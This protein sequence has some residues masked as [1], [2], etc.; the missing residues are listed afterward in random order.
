MENQAVYI[1][2]GPCG[3]GKS[4]V[5]KGL[6]RRMERVVL[7]EGD[8]LHSMF[9]GEEQPSWN[10][11]LSIVW[12]NILLLTK[13]F[14]ANKLTI[15]IDYVVE[16]ELKWFCEQLLVEQVKI[17]YVVLRADEEALVKRLTYRGDKYLIKRSLLLLNQLEND[18]ANKRHLYDATSKK[19]N[20]IIEDIQLRITDF[21]IK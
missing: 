4:T 18:E 12:E 11:Q 20:K 3:V 14:L 21:E 2:S 5:T 13:N 7:I 6:V 8:Q 16:D 19:P 10:E 1:F 9:I 17:Y 15:V